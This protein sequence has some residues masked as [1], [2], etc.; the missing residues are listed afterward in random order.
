MSKKAAEHEKASEHHTPAARHHGEAAKH[1]DA[2]N[3]EKAAH[4]RTGATKPTGSSF[5]LPKTG[6]P[7]ALRDIA[8][9]GTAQ[10]KQAYENIRAATGE[11]SNTIKNAYSRGAQGAVDYN[12]KLIEVARANTNAAFDYVHEL[13]GVKSLS[14]FVEVSAGHARKQ[15]EMLSEQSKELTALAQKVT[16]E[17]TEPLKAG[18]TNASSKIV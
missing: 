15:F 16:L 4:P 11:A 1:H 7:E 12:V 17:T 6:A 8:D 5:D 10:A 9:Q 18:L 14:G 3:H 13:L 2:G